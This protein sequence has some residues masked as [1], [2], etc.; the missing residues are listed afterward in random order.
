MEP[1]SQVITSSWMPHKWG[2]ARAHRVGAPAFLA[3]M[4]EHADWY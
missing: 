1:E 3:G 2:G 4:Q